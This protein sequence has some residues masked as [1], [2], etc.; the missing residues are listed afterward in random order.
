MHGRSKQTEDATYR[1]ASVIAVVPA[2]RPPTDLMTHLRHHQ[3]ALTSC[4]QTSKAAHT[5]GD[6]HTDS[7]EVVGG[8][9]VVLAL[10]TTKAPVNI[11]K[12][13]SPFDGWKENDIF[14][15]TVFRIYP[16]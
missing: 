4:E 11:G 8:V 15:L 3:F 2:A 5:H 1:G 12:T 10:R 13:P 9:L 16:V 14:V 6:P 7:H